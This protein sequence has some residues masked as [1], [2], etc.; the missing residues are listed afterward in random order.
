[1]SLQNVGDVFQHDLGV[2]YDAEL[3]LPS[4]LATLASEVSDASARTLFQQDRGDAARQ[5]A[6]LERCFQLLGIPPRRIDAAVVDA[7]A[8]EHAAFA[9]ENP[10]PDA[11]TLLDLDLVERIKQTEITAYRLLIA[12]ANLLRQLA[13]QQLLQENQRQEEELA[14]EVE[15]ASYLLMERLTGAGPLPERQFATRVGGQRSSGET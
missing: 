12:K 9:R 8:A 1:M 6:N 13:C 2:I 7:L 14:H 4:L 15:R 10:S 5:I 3:K 11:L